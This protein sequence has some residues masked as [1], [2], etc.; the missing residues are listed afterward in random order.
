[1]KHATGENCGSPGFR[2]DWDWFKNCLF[3][4]D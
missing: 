2:P 4:H 3:K 1:L